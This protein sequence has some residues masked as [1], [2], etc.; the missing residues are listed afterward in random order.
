MTSAE[1][2]ND[3][4]YALTR[5]VFERVDALGQFAPVLQTLTRE[6]MLEGMSA[7]IHPGALEY[8]MEA[9]LAPAA[10]GQPN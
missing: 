9:G 7:P 2:P 6:S 1:T 8:F 3:V 10:P 5:S 4:V